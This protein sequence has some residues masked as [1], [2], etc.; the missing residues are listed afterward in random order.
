MTD[1]PSTD[2]RERRILIVSPSHRISNPSTGTGTRLNN[3]MR[4]VSENAEVIALVP[5]E[6]TDDPP[7]WVSRVYGFHAYLPGYLTDLNV[8]FL[9]TVLRIL[10]TEEIDIIQ[11][12]LPKGVCL[13][14]VLTTLSGVDIP[15]VYAAQNVE[16]DH[17][18]NFV[19]ESLP[20]YKR[21][22]GPRIIPFIEELTVTCADHVTTVSEK[23]KNTFVRRYGTDEESIAVIPT[24]AKNVD[25]S[26]L[27]PQQE[28]RRRFGL[29]ADTIA[30]FH[31][32]YGHP[33]NREAMDLVSRR[34][35]PALRDAPV[36]IQFLLV[37][38]GVP[39]FDNDGI[40]TAGFVDD[41][42]SVLNVAD[43][44]VVPIRHGGGTK[45][46]V[47]DYL[48][49]GIPFVTTEKG[50]EG[51]DVRH[52]RHALI[53]DTV[54]DQF[55]DSVV[56]I[57]NDREKRRRLSENMASLRDEHLDWKNS[58]RALESFHDE[59]LRER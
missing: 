29:T 50:V 2:R 41:L 55:V 34:I 39:R 20:W 58:A 49:L 59:I 8:S 35:E 7:Q 4:G 10:D 43:L 48:S 28:V 22:V 15:V 18:A 32:N 47:F 23:D 40:V 38:P 31:G 1:E 56:R 26:A 46:K 9:R 11:V 44:A 53:T 45:T 14:K 13:T 6:F 16:R 57:S 3:L 5:E 52:D 19:S 27:R 42:F 12:A 36:D 51:I 24:G 17:A 30:V 33:P 37:G 21:L 54:N 25:E